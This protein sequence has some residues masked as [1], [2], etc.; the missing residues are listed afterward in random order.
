LHQTSFTAVTP[1]G[2]SQGV[3]QRQ[4]HTGHDREGIEH[5]EREAYLDISEPVSRPK[6]CGESSKE[7]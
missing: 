6:Q 2:R 7:N 3:P 1:Q 5:F 4:I